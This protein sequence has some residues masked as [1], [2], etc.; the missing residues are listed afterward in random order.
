MSAPPWVTDMKSS[1]IQLGK[2]LNDPIKGITALSRVGVSF[3]Q[4]QKDQIER[5]SRPAT[6][7]ARRRSSSPS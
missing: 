4:Q 5:W 3:T 7:W 1:A 6:R 2:A